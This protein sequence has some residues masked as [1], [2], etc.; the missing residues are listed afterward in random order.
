MNDSQWPEFHQVAIHV[1]EGRHDLAV[2]ML[3]MLGHLEW[4]YDRATL[5][6]EVWDPAEE[7][8]VPTRIEGQMSF[9][10]SVLGGKELE[11]LSYRGRSHHALAGTDL[12]NPT[13]FISH[14]STHVE[15]VDQM[16]AALIERY[17]GDV[18]VVHRF[19]TFNHR[20]PAI[21]GKKRFKEV[22]LGTRRIIGFDVKLIQRLTEGPWEI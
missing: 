16:S 13:G 2:N 1:S 14:M 17:G 22:V 18:R 12:A 8:M 11:I 3:V 5:V 15:D 6:G 10:Y 4:V 7:E 20:N 9:N 19:E 21:V